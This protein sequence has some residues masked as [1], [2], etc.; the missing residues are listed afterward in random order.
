MNGIISGECQQLRSR[1]NDILNNANQHN[2]QNGAQTV[3]SS[4]I[5]QESQCL[6]KELN[7]LISKGGFSK[8]HS[9]L[10]SADNNIYNEVEIV[11]ETEE[12]NKFKAYQEEY[13][14]NESLMSIRRGYSQLR[15]AERIGSISKLNI[16][17]QKMK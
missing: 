1:I 5:L 11:V 15:S 16:Q 9:V 3:Q 12:T 2:P 6:Q 10:E 7:D 13:G 8:K 4:I 17:A 14:H